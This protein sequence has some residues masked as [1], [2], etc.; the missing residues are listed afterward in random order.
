MPPNLPDINLCG[1]FDA[2]ESNFYADCGNLFSSGDDKL[3]VIHILPSNR[4][5]CYNLKY[6]ELHGR[7]SRNPWSQREMGIYQQYN[8][9]SHR[10]RCILLQPADRVTQALESSSYSH[11]NPMVFHVVCLSVAELKWGTYLKYLHL[12]LAK[13]TVTIESKQESVDLTSIA[14]QNQRDSRSLKA[15]SRVTT[16]YL[17]ATLIAV[18][19][20][21]PKHD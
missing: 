10:T 16:S 9:S 8:T 1:E 7:K 13:E 17:P 19:V 5:Y 6:M 3:N 11:D 15:L 20:H 14:R 4:E 18:S 12:Q 21:S 2:Q